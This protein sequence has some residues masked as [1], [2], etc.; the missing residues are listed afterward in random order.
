M[1]KT[2]KNPIENDFDEELANAVKFVLKNEGIL[3]G[4]K[5]TFDKIE[6]SLKRNEKTMEDIYNTLDL[7]PKFKRY[8]RIS[9]GV[10]V[11]LILFAAFQLFVMLVLMGVIQ[12]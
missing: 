4:L 8:A 2:E 1:P 9:I 5:L 12:R 6:K 10:S 3:D 11:L 7:L